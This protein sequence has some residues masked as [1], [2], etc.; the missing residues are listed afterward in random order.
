MR[1]QIKKWI[2]ENKVS[3]KELAEVADV[4]EKTVSN[5]LIGKSDIKSNVL[6]LWSKKWPEMLSYAFDL[7]ENEKKDAMNLAIDEAIVKLLELRGIQNAKMKY[8]ECFGIKAENL[9]ENGET[10]F[11]FK[12]GGFFNF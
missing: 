1:E 8:E 3:Q 6:E 9:D 7:Y 2:V 12:G 4:T 5:F 10:K 11:E